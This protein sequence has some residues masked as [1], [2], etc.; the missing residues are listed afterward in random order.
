MGP[1][2]KRS[3]A[4]AMMRTLGRASR[5]AAELEPP[6]QLVQGV[7]LGG[8]R[9]ARR[10]GLFNHGR[11]L[12]GDLVHLV[13]GGVQLRLA[14]AQLN[15]AFHAGERLELGLAVVGG[16]DKDGVQYRGYGAG[17]GNSAAA[18]LGPKMSSGLSY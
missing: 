12:L 9:V 8:E 18:Q 16:D 1:G 4:C 5:H 3:N 15:D 10:G 14:D 17:N 13:D 6:D 11:V 7:C 2:S